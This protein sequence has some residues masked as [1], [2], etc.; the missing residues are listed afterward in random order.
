VNTTGKIIKDLTLKKYLKLLEFA[1]KSCRINDDDRSRDNECK[2][3][4]NQCKNFNSEITEISLTSF[5]VHTKKSNNLCRCKINWQHF[6]VFIIIFLLNISTINCLA[7]R[8]EG[9]SL[10]FIFLHNFSWENLS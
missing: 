2:N 9:K 4:K 1:N 8:Q 5:N 3:N 7:A 6:L 10:H